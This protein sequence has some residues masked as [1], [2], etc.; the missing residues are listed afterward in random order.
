MKKYVGISRFSH[1]KRLRDQP[2]NRLTDGHDLLQKCEDALK[3]DWIQENLNCGWVSNKCVFSSCG[4]VCCLFIVFLYSFAIY[5][6]LI[7]C[8][9]KIK[10]FSIF[11]ICWLNSQ[12]R[13]CISLLDWSLDWSLGWSLDWSLYWSLDSLA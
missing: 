10:F 9:S 2:T 4:H 7:Y 3:N 11:I 1:F 8:C 12:L 6:M 5:C 13:K